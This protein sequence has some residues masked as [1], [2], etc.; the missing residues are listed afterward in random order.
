MGEEN[1][2]L[3]MTLD[4]T[5]LELEKLVSDHEYMSTKV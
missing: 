1:K 3:K 4:E 2:V 5:Q